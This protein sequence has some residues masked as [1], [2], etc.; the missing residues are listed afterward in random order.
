MKPQRAL[1]PCVEDSC[2]GTT[3]SRLFH[4]GFSGTPPRA[5][6]HSQNMP[7]PNGGLVASDRGGC[8]LPGA[9]D[10]IYVRVRFTSSAPLMV[11]PL[12]D[13]LLLDHGEDC[14]NRHL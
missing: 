1:C 7:Q 14:W 8:G 2:A 5:G 9:G 10:V 4:S 12:D 3:T 11:G 13:G 6:A